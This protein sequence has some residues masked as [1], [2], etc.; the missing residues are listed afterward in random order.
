MTDERCKDENMKL[1]KLSSFLPRR[2]LP[3]CKYKCEK[4]YYI[5]DFQRVLNVVSTT[6]TTL[7]IGNES[8][9]VA[10]LSTT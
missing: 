2:A 8:S 6:S 5:V 3:A 4:D 9:S 1:E 10:Y 7:L